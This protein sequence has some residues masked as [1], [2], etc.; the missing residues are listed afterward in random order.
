MLA[1]AN[2]SVVVVLVDLHGGVVGVLLK[3]MVMGCRVLRL[4]DFKFLEAFLW[5]LVETFL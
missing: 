4:Q 3:N 2:S 1:G 5:T